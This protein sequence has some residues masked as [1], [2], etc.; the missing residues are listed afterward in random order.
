MISIVC[1]YNDKEILQSHLLRGLKVQTSEYDLVLI[2]NTADQ[3]KSAAEGLNYGGQ[4]A[5]GEYIMF[6]H[7]DVTLKP[8][9][10]F[11]LIERTLGRLPNLGI[12]GAAGCIEAPVW[13][14]MHGRFVLSNVMH[15]TPPTPAGAIP[16]TDATIVQTLDECLI[17]VPKETFEKLQFDE[18]TCDGWHL[19]AVD[20]CLSVKALGLDAYVLPITVYHRSFPGRVQGDY[21]K[22]LKRVLRKHGNQQRRISTTCGTWDTRSPF[23]LRFQRFGSLAYSWL[24]VLRREGP[25]ESASRTS[26]YLRRR[27]RTIKSAAS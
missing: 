10:S 20:Y 26:K 8:R 18:Q 3:F 24:Q 14:G 22:T 6:T 12:A 19:Y 16:V 9:D 4:I 15:G 2:D 7:Q 11:Q 21:Y 13:F 23:P 5:K 1:V 25:I 27:K 17:I